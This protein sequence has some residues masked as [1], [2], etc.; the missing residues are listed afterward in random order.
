MRKL[1]RKIKLYF[2][3]KKVKRSFK[4]NRFIY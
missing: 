4:N 1:I 3:I 2:I